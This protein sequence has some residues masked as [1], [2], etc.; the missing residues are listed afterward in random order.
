[1]KYGGMKCMHMLRLYDVVSTCIYMYMCML[2]N[3]HV[4]VHVNENAWGLGYV[5]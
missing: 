5:E 3:V 1:M 4:H 2:S